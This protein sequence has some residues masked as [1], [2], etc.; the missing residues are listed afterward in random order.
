LYWWWWTFII[1]GAQIYEDYFN[2]ADKLYLTEIDNDIEGDILLKGL[3]LKEWDLVSTSDDI[4]ENGITYRFKN[5]NRNEYGTKESWNIG[6][7]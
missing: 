7:S 4:I 6:S 2:F 1:G 3:D 5:Y